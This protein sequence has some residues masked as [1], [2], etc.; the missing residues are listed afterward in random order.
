VSGGARPVSQVQRHGSGGPYEAAIGYSR[1]VVAGGTAWTAGC[2]ATVEGELVGVG[3]PYAQAVAA[4]GVGL[5]ALERA[6]FEVGDVV[7]TRMYVIDVAANSEE[8]G[9][10]HGSLFRDVRPAATMVGVA[11][12]IDPQM[13]VEVELVAYRATHGEGEQ[14]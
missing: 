6:G 4:F 11:A 7:Q 9:R 12:L 14:R 1:V 3:D 8:V 13:L 5:A 2:T 10:A